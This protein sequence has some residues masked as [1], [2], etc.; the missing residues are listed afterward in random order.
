MMI[1]FLFLRI[2]LYFSILPLISSLISTKQLLIKAPIHTKIRTSCLRKCA[3][4]HAAK[5]ARP[6]AIEET[7][8][9]VFGALRPLRLPGESVLGTVGVP[10]F[11][12]VNN[13]DTDTDTDTATLKIVD[14]LDRSNIRG[15]EGVLN[16]GP[17][18]IVD[19]VLTKEACEAIIQDCETTAG[20]F[21]NYNSGKNHHGAL[22]ILVSEQTAHAVSQRLSQHIDIVQVESLRKEMMATSE[23]VVEEK[24]DARLIFAGLNR[25]WRI[26]R[27]D[28][29]GQETFAPHIDA[30]FPP[31]GISEDGTT[32]L[33]DA[34]AADQQGEQDEIVSRLTLLM[35]LN[36]DF[37]GGE[38]NFYGPNAVYGDDPP[39]LIASVRPK[40]GSCLLFPQGVGEAAVE[41]ARQHWPLHE[42]SPV[43]SGRPKYVIRSDV[44]FVTQREP[45]Q[46]DDPLFQYDHLVRQTFLPASFSTINKR[47]LG[48]TMSLYNPHMGVEN[49]GPFLYSFLRFTKQRRIVEI[50]AGYTSL[51][52][53]QALKENDDELERIRKLQQQDCC[54][55]LNYPWVVPSIVQDYDK[56]PASLLCID[57]CEHQKET[58]T[59]ASAVAKSLGLESYLQFQK[60]DAFE[61]ELEPNSVDVLWC[62]F[63]VGS[64][65]RDYV[66]SSWK[67]LRP[68]GFLLCH[69]TLTNENTRNWLEAVRTKSPQEVTGISPDEFVELSLL[70]P[71][72]HYQNSITLIQKRK[73]SET[74][75]SYKEPLYSTFA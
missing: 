61:L 70:E 59:G 10:T 24:E 75:M 51:W 26:Y 64:R 46:L 60:G 34:S 68:G 4:N 57:N 33:W 66:S 56:E 11:A 13:Q 40:T 44:L 6:Q 2:S 53:L 25:R 15:L 12:A 43:R 47:F 39:Q 31:S 28:S 38:T 30:G 23:L 9:S 21:G 16:Q 14:T 58:A 72:K 17:A 50:G 36:D 63:G 7:H 8:S 37:V 35:Y 49:L 52:I 20:G 74:G 32:L 27:Y 73:S 3:A 42:G 65:M 45:L 69:S 18:C 55:L 41:H 54:M 5:E 71:H 1:L 19:H 67:S 48:H 29:N 62:D 22:Q